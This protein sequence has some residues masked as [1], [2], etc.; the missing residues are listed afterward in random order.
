MFESFRSRLVISNLFITLLGLLVVVLVFTQVLSNRSQSIKTDALTSDSRLVSKEIEYLFQHKAS[1]LDLQ[2]LVISTSRVLKVEVTIVDSRGT[3]IV[4]S[5]RYTPFYNGAW[6]LDRTALKNA[7]TA[8]EQLKSSSVRT[9]QAPLVGITT[10]RLVGAVILVADVSDVSPGLLAL[11]NVLL[12][13]LG[14]ALLVWLLVGLYFT[15]SISRPLV[16]VIGA[17]RRMALG[18][19]DTRV[20]ARGNG[21]MARLAASFNH[22]AEQIQQ[23]DSVLKD[24]V[25]NVSHDLRTPLTMISGFSQALVDGT[26]RDGEV[27]ESA[28]VIHEEAMKMQHMVDDLLQLTRLE[29][30]LQIFRRAP[31]EVRPF[32]QAIVDRIARARA[33]KPA[34][35]LRNLTPRSL[36]LMDV[37]REQIERALRNLLDNALQYT[38]PD[39]TVTVSARA[40]GRGWVEITVKDSG[41]GIPQADL[42]R[43]FERFYRT[44]K[45]RERVHGHS[46]LG[47]AIVREIVEGHGGQIQ[48]E[49]VPNRGTTFRFTVPQADARELQRDVPVTRESVREPAGR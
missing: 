37:D 35:T 36:P 49:S 42:A 28:E 41:I 13:V 27:Q 33:N 22:M 34:A 45:G 39:G 15:F 17:T 24:F 23:T 9:F 26:A 11:K 5:K 12:A 46:G 14:T 1:F 20:P 10:H 18:Q 38:P 31:V 47:L 40:I 19:Y 29:S 16:R 21:E 4:D 2:N 25:A 7:Q 43:V 30:G 44:D 3:I 8:S 6:S 48:V 32:V